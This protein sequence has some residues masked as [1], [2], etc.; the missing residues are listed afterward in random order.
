MS[1]KIVNCKTNTLFKALSLNVFCTFVLTFVNICTQVDNGTAALSLANTLK[2]SGAAHKLHI[3]ISLRRFTAE[4][5]AAVPHT[6]ENGVP[7][8]RYP[9]K[10][11]VQGMEPDVAALLAGKELPPES[12]VLVQ[13]WEDA[14][15]EATKSEYS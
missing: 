9:R 7:V 12:P 11:S 14:K 2:Q 5:A 10:F 6:D 8:R 15:R 4:F 1:S 3:F 13:A